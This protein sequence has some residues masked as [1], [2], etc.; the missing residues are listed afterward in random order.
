MNK[1]YTIILLLSLVLTS[2]NAQMKEVKNLEAFNNR[3]TEMATQIKSIESDFK[4]VKHLDIFNEDVTSKGRFY[5]IAEDKINLS[6]TQP[7]DYKIIINGNRIRID[8]DGKTSIVSLKSNKVMNEMRSMLAACMSGNISKITNY[9]MTFFEDQSSYLVKIK[10]T[11]KSL[12]AYISGFDIYLAKTDMSVSKLRIYET[13]N[14]YTDYI[15]SNRKFNTLKD[16]A[17]FKIR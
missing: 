14:D 12:E 3:V 11:D 5:Y 9:K 16:D 10:P 8:S 1:I 2:A 13:G 7:T 6:Y 15:F 17:L 4:Q